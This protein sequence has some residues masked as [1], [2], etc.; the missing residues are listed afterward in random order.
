MFRR[1]H[2]TKIALASVGEGPRPDFRF[3][4]A[5]YSTAHESALEL[6]RWSV[7]HRERLK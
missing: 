7:T 2:F 5:C 3:G 6:L 4:E 1:R